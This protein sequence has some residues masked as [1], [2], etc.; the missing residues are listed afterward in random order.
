MDWRQ[1]ATSSYTSTVNAMLGAAVDF[2]LSPDETSDTL[3]RAMADPRRE[4]SVADYLDRIAG[5]L[6]REILAKQR[7]MLGSS[8][9]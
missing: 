8:G 7:R 1:A 6:A 9:L 5:A 4:A 2:G 3:H